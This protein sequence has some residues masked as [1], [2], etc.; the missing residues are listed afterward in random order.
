MASSD[1]VTIAKAIDNL[2]SKLT[3][4]RRPETDEVENLHLALLQELKTISQKLENICQ[5]LGKNEK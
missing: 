1:A 4:V 2:A 3:R 5:K